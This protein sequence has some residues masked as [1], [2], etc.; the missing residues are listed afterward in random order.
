MSE[1]G[2]EENG[3]GRLASRLEILGA[4]ITPPAFLTGLLY[5][6]AT[7]RE[8]AVFGYFGVDASMVDFSVQQ[9]LTRAA[10]VMF[11]PVA[12]A[13]FAGLVAVVAHVG[14][15]AATGLPP[16]RRHPRRLVAGVT[17]ALAAASALL[18]AVG[19]ARLDGHY[20]VTRSAP[21]SAVALGVGALVCEY[22]F[23]VP[24][25]LRARMRASRQAQD[26]QAQDGSGSPPAGDEAP[27]PKPP[28]FG[29]RAVVARRVMI[30]GLLLIAVFWATTLF[31]DNRGT[32]TA[33]TIAHNLPFDRGV[34][35]Y[36][37][38]RL[39][40]RGP[41]VAS[42]PIDGRSAIF[43][44][45]YTGLHLLIRSNGRL[46]LLPTGW[47]RGDRY[48]VIVVADDPAVVRLDFLSCVP[49]DPPAGSDAAAASC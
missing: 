26:G 3:L 47:A 6:F 4:L 20:L 42:P 34:V 30:G 2:G 24:D 18:L 16:A 40:V 44:Y 31:A 33:R 25:V 41:G 1:S 9:Y 45:R 29:R 38:Q 39:Q 13:L 43:R 27:A 10:G 19:L 32:R 17:A 14:L 35:L 37:T 21:R 46:F 36:S 15:V 11:L 23:V 48:P 22:A 28:L 49:R 12:S 7:V 5:Y 8:R